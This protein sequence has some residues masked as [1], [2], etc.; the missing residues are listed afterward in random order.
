MSYPAATCFF[1]EPTGRI[2][3]YFRRYADGPPC[4]ISG[5]YHNAL[6]P[7]DVIAE[8]HNE[9]GWL[10]VQEH[11]PHTDPGWPKACQCGYMFEETDSW[12]VFTDKIFRRVD[13][14]YETPL[15]DAPPGAMWNADCLGESMQGPDGLSLMVRLP[16]GRDWLI[17]GPASNCT[18]PGDSSHRCWCRHGVPPMITVD[19]VSPPGWSTCSAGAGSIQAGD[20]HGFLRDGTLTAG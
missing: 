5:S 4:P 12:Q 1:L 9:R 20:Y 19:K 10:A 8:V 14:A 13:T 2:Q 15:R 18:K 16:N 17:D 7:L 11:P 6:V 3:R